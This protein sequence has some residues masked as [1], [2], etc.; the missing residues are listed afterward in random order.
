[1][2]HDTSCK[3]ITFRVKIHV[4][5]DTALFLGEKIIKAIDFP[6]GKRPYRKSVTLLHVYKNLDFHL[7]DK[8][9]LNEYNIPLGG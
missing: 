4:L 6:Q 3:D 2:L 5:L 8:V 7:E 1:M 9:F